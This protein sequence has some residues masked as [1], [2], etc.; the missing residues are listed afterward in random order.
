MVGSLF[1]HKALERGSCDCEWVRRCHCCYLLGK[2]ARLELDVEMML[3]CGG[4]DVGLAKKG[5][6]DF[7]LRGWWGFRGLLNPRDLLT[8]ELS[9]GTYYFGHGLEMGKHSSHGVSGT[10]C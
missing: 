8:G 9:F 1:F 10:R 4:V 7:V 6:R 2:V 5:T 3:G